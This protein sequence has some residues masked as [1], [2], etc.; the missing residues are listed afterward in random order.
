MGR[1]EQRIKE[2]VL[3]RVA[4][5]GQCGGGY[6]F[7]DVNVLGHK[8]DLWFLMLICGKCHQAVG[9]AAV[10][11][12]QSLSAAGGAGPS[13]ERQ[14]E[15]SSDEPPGQQREPQGEPVTADDV[16]AIRDFLR[17]FDG[18]FRRLLGG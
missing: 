13:G 2:L 7:S 6:E 10:V 8:E 3:S 15:T 1:Q 9:V 4:K 5:C 14:S 12:E 17:G 18:D 11:K 16:A